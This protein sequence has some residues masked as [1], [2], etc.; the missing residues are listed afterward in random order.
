MLCLIYAYSGY[1]TFGASAQGTPARRLQFGPSAQS[2]Q[3]SWSKKSPRGFCKPQ[4]N[5]Q[6]DTVKSVHTSHRHFLQGFSIACYAEWCTRLILSATCSW[7]TLVSTKIWFV[8]IFTW[9][10]W[11]GGV[12]WQW[13]CRQRQFLMLSLP[14]LW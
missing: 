13:G 14:M 12:K 9:I 11:T 8:W 4:E 2:Q 6:V 3:T 10:H 1:L 5:C 7:G